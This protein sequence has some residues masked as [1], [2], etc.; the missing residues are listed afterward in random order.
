MPSLLSEKTD[1]ELRLQVGLAG[2]LFVALAIGVI[3][4][5]FTP[6]YA[7]VGYRPE[8]PVP[9]SH[10][11]HAGQLGLSCLYCHTHVD[12][13]VFANVPATQTCM[14]CHAKIQANSPLLAEVRASYESG[15][16][17]RWK[18]I[19]QL[20][21]YAYFNHAVHVQRGVSCISCHG[22][23]NQM[24]VVFHAESLSMSWCLD[25]HRNPTPN[26]R[27]PSEVTN[28]DWQPPEG[29][30][31]AQVG[32]EIQERLLIN[33]PETCQACHR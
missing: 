9:F 12:D 4:Y 27:P 2:V 23:V 16:P 33:P 22:K 19:H 11:I 20:P 6:K 28:L 25:C 8:Q 5:Y 21:D 18:K 14:N 26:L 15:R 32:L 10:E 17:V 13:S 1:R 24:K 29:K 31:A 30:T 3:W 7:R